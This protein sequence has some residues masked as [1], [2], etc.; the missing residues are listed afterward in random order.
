[1]RFASPVE[2]ALSIAKYYSALLTSYTD[3]KNTKQGTK[4]S[5]A[6]FSDS[7]L[8]PLCLR[9]LI[10]YLTMDKRIVVDIMSITL[11]CSASFFDNSKCIARPSSHR[12]GSK[13]P[14]V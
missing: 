9:G 4:S 3:T 1:M 2:H 10:H 11:H 7:S 13:T 12:S 6:E 14:R 5:I 8:C